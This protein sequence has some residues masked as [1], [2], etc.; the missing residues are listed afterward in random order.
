MVG[1]GPIW[2]GCC[3]DPPFGGWRLVIPP[4]RSAEAILHPLANWRANRAKTT[5]RRPEAAQFSGRRTVPYPSKGSNR[6][7]HGSA[8]TTRLS[9]PI[10]GWAAPSH[11]ARE[12]MRCY[13]DATG[14]GRSPNCPLGQTRRP[15][16][17]ASEFESI[18]RADF[19]SKRIN[20]QLRE[21][22]IITCRYRRS[23][24]VRFDALLH[25]LSTVPVFAVTRVFR[26][27]I[28]ELSPSRS[29]F[30]ADKRTFEPRSLRCILCWVSLAPPA[31]PPANDIP[32]R[33]ADVFH[34][35]KTL[36]NVVDCR[37]EA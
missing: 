28:S 34:A 11:L 16:Q 18:K 20:E 12:L 14:S 17:L 30:H 19:P 32:S 26:I 35:N 1:R 27:T 3:P 21:R 2:L 15:R 37:A 5:V 33:L 13:V 24:V 8:E 36:K 10:P 22:R 6:Y 7:R 4:C 31:T 23:I 9:L 29:D 25:N